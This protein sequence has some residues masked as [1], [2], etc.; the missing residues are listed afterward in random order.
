MGQRAFGSSFVGVIRIPRTWPAGSPFEREVKG[1][2]TANR[3]LNPS[4]RWCCIVSCDCGPSVSSLLQCEWSVNVA[5]GSRRG[6][7]SKPVSCHGV[8][9]DERDPGPLAC[10]VHGP[11][12]FK[13]PRLTTFKFDIPSR[14]RDDFLSFSNIRRIGFT[15]PSC[16]SSSGAIICR[17]TKCWRYR[18][19]PHFLQKRRQS[20]SNRR[21]HFCTM[22]TAGTRSPE[23][24]SRISSY[25]TFGRSFLRVGEK[26]I[27]G[28]HSAF[29]PFTQALEGYFKRRRTLF[30]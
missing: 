8:E 6:T 15:S 24:M 2:S 7:T 13:P 17:F 20:L 3:V 27:K 19:Q 1:A 14:P 21:S 4:V 22:S 29:F 23:T 9:P 5:G 28:P 12:S 26:A 18:D 10:D 25:H 30:L 16:F 11:S